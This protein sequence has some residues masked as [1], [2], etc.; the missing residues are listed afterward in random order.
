[1]LR[2]TSQRDS[3]NSF[4]LLDEP[5]KVG[6]GYSIYEFHPHEDPVRTSIA[7]RYIDVRHVVVEALK[8]VPGELVGASLGDLSSTPESGVGIG[9]CDVVFI[10]QKG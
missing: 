8:L 4:K 9:L 3:D 10:P 2:I 7:G 5:S 6:A 1:M